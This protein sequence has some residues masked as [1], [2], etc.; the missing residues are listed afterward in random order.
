M[1][2]NIR[3]N[4]LLTCFFAVCF[5]S[6]CSIHRQSALGRKL[7]VKN[8][9]N[10]I[11]KNVSQQENI[12]ADSVLSLSASNTLSATEIT[13][14][15][16]IKDSTSQ[17]RSSSGVRKKRIPTQILSSFVSRSELHQIM[18]K[19]REPKNGWEKKKHIPIPLLAFHLRWLP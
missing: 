1:I 8:K 18:E 10:Q 2:G 14:S 11:D 4:N 17:Y 13:A 3:F 5:F 9:A 16:P 6:S 15:T 19:K 12:R 7:F